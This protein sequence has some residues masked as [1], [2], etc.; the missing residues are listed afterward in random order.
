MS[1]Q[2]YNRQTITQYLLG[3]LSAAETERFDELSITDH[4]FIDE[5]NSAE[6]DLIDSYVNGELE[7][8]LQIQFENHYLTSPVRRERVQLARSFYETVPQT[9]DANQPVQAET[10]WITR[11]RSSLSPGT[12][13]PA[14]R[15]QWAFAGVVL[16]ALCLVI[17]TWV[18]FERSR[19]PVPNTQIAQTENPREVP[20]ETIA[21]PQP[22]PQ[23]TDQVAPQEEVRPVKPESDNSARNSANVVSVALAPQMRGGTAES[24]VT[25]T[26][27]TDLVAV[28]LELEPND[29]S[30]YRVLL[31]N[32][33]GQGLWRS[34]RSLPRTKNG[35]R[36][37]SLR[38]PA[39][40]LKPRSYVLR[41]WGLSETGSAEMITDYRFRVV[42][43]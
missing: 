3:A 4:S 11:R 42:G 37:L 8:P 27:N 29:Y 6:R 23:A 30:A 20:H 1:Q 7:S 17:V 34:N 40:L 31:L 13:R 10:S 15:W 5:L 14:W 21:A 35:D 26:P 28:R 43:Q 18:M 39:T 9:I 41:V 22:T 16:V 24:V 38:I 33:A 36:S 32:Q 19:R 12:L 2:P 25:V